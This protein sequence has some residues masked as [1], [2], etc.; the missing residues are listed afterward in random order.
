MRYSK[1]GRR[2]RRALS[3][4]LALCMMLG[5][6]PPLTMTAQAA[7]SAAAARIYALRDRYPQGCYWNHAGPDLNG[8]GVT[9]VPCPSHDSYATCNSHVYNGDTSYQCRGF[10]K[11]IFKE[12][13]GQEPDDLPKNYNIENV[14]PGDYVR[15]GNERAG[16]SFI[17]L[18]R[19]GDEVTVLEC[20]IGGRC[21]IQWGR[22]QSLSGALNYASASNPKYVYFSYSVHASNYD[23]LEM[24]AGF[25]MPEDPSYRPIPDDSF[26][27]R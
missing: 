26:P 1:A 15:F 12:V 4:L 2:K 19:N 7:G 3:G 18:E 9:E 11:V 10:A 6:L 22:V 8:Y 25:A 20:N 17:V 27:G 23:E 24:P 13:F 5:L 21:I 14:M 16:H